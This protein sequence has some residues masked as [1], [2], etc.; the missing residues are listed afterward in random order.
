MRT[1]IIIIASLLVL[2]F[3]WY[4]TILDNRRRRNAS[5]GGVSMFS[6]RYQF[7]ALATKESLILAFLTLVMAG[8]IAALIA[9]DKAGYLGPP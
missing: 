9:L 4:G 2:A 3:L 8:F 1:P 7:R 6:L 5:E